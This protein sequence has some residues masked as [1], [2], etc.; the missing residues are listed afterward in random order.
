MTPR[1]E[2]VDEDSA[3][4]FGSLESSYEYVRLLHQAVEE[5]AQDIDEEIARGTIDGERRL[6]ALRIIRYKL[7]QLDNRLQSS[8]CILNDLR[9]LRRMLLGERTSRQD[10]SDE[11]FVRSS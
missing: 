7:T 1:G 4:P 10:V 11:E 5:A 6:D 2:T 8:R 9:T 3:N